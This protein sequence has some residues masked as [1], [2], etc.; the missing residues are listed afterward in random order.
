MLMCIPPSRYCN[1]VKQGIAKAKLQPGF[2]NFEKRSY[3]VLYSLSHCL[4]AGKNV[5]GVELGNGWYSAGIVGSKK[6][7]GGSAMPGGRPHP[8]QLL[9]RARATVGTS[10]SLLV[11]GKEWQAASGPIIEDSLYN[12]EIY[13]ARREL[14]D[15]HSRH[16][17]HPDYYTNAAWTPAVVS[18]AMPNTTKLV[19]Q[20]MPPIQKIRPLQ[21]KKIT[22]PAAGIHVVDFGQNTAAI[23]RMRITK[24]ARGANVSS[25]AICTQSNLLKCAR[26]LTP[27]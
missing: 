13:D 4:K 18:S 1:G 3:Y 8:P 17:S 21:A 11:S 5:L 27:S 26:N 20:L 19:P 6:T 25:Q 23:V 7:T 12:G 10:D 14:K 24:L 16:F 2:T 22:S 9:L 15:T